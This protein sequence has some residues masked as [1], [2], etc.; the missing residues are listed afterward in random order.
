MEKEKILFKYRCPQCG[1]KYLIED[2]R[3][4]EIFCQ[5]CG[6]VLEETIDLGPEWRDFKGEESRSR[7][8]PPKTGMYEHLG[9]STIISPDLKDVEG[10]AL[11]NEAR[12]HLSELR[13][14]DYISQDIR[15]KKNL[16]QAAN[17]LKIYADKLNLPDYVI[18]GAMQIYK[19]AFKNDLVKGRAIR[20]IIAA[21]AYAACRI[22]N[23]PRDL[24]EFEKAYP[25]VTK[26][27]V[28][29]DYRLL[30]RYL[31][32]KVQS[33]DPAIYINK[34]A[35]KLSLNQNIIQEALKMLNKAEEIGA[36]K[37]KDPVGIAAAVLY[38]TC[39]EK[40]MNVAQKD[41]AQASGITLVTLRN[42]SNDLERQ[43][44]KEI[45]EAA[46]AK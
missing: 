39:K 19:E 44:K 34:I 31:N 11:P 5:S 4:G 32:L 1:S 46:K 17:F 21:A 10:R 22:S 13:K 7:A 14:A 9:L 23:T 41:V 16:E 24:R 8:G 35:S 42:R 26:R 18:E 40:K 6:Y 20:S 30:M 27:D 12:K 38:L 3:S 33:P 29:R 45:V 43:L 28:A 37:G 25:V 36:T 2:E 15:K